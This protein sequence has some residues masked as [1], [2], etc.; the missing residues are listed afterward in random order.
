MCE[1]VVKILNINVIASVAG[2]LTSFWLCKYQRLSSL[3][4]LGLLRLI[5]LLSILW[6]LLA[7]L[8]VLLS[9]SFAVQ[10]WFFLMW[11]NVPCFFDTGSGWSYRLLACWLSPSSIS[12]LSAILLV[13]F[14][15]AS[16]E[17]LLPFPF[18]HT[19]AGST[20]FI[21]CAFLAQTVHFTS[22]VLKVLAFTSRRLRWKISITHPHFAFPTNLTLPQKHFWGLWMLYCSW[23]QYLHGGMSK[24]HGSLNWPL[25]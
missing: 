5:R 25:T 12:L 6:W 2:M 14:F 11:T 23:G 1:K 21:S 8:L 13:V 24:F 9:P 7:L 19:S 15:P 18:Q 22:Y 17:V 3:S 20:W 4:S 16:P 10:Y